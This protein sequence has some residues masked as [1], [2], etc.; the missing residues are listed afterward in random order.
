MSAAH[1][2][3]GR[4]Q[5]ARTLRAHDIP[6]ASTRAR[7]PSHADRVAV[8]RRCSC[9][10]IVGTDEG[11]AVRAHRGRRARVRCAGARTGDRGGR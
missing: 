6:A 9:V 4:A 5:T 7:R 8:R 3:A 10:A 2:T 1:T 11:Y